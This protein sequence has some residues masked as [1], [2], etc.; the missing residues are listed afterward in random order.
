MTPRIRKEGL[1]WHKR[2]VL[3]AV[4]VGAATVAINIY[5]W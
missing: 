5:F 1:A 2:R 3:L 4:I